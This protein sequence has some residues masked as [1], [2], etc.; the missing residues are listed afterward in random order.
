MKNKKISH[1]N[2]NTI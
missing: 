2:K 1:F